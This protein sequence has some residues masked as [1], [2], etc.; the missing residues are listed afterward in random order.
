MFFVHHC[1][2]VWHSLDENVDVCT[3]YLTISPQMDTRIT[4]SL[5]SYALKCFYLWPGIVFCI[6]KMNW[7][8]QCGD[9]IQLTSYKI[10]VGWALSEPVM[11]RLASVSDCG[12]AA[13]LSVCRVSC[14]F[15]SRLTDKFLRPK[16]TSTARRCR[17]K[18]CRASLCQ[19]IKSLLIM[20]KEQQRR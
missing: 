20:K 15:F 9:K 14:T 11:V 16:S 4:H 18:L 2:F 3:V 13:S 5:T 17:C 19:E 12:G 6:T 8:T 1:H 7:K 10:C